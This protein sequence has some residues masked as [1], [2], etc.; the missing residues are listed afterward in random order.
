MCVCVCVCVCLCG[1]VLEIACCCTV[2]FVLTRRGDERPPTH[3]PF[4]YHPLPPPPIP[5]P[6]FN[7]FFPPTPA[8]RRFTCDCRWTATGPWPRFDGNARSAICCPS[9]ATR[10]SPRS[11]GCALRLACKIHRVFWSFFWRG[12]G[13]V[14]LRFAL[15][16]YKNVRAQMY[17]LDESN[18]KLCTSLSYN[19]KISNIVGFTVDLSLKDINLL[20]FASVSILHVQKVFISFVFF[21]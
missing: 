18:S 11:G 5:Q 13:T 21:L 14:L 1:S 4:L 16:I 12:G 15:Q 19:S 8:P 2:P 3:R 9:C 6:P 17:Q 20:S 10:G 7:P